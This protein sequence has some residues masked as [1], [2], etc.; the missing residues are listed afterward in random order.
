MRMEQLKKY[1]YCDG[2]GGFRISFLP[3]KGGLDEQNA[4]WVEDIERLIEAL[5]KAMNCKK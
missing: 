5:N 2:F 4:I 1:I 3:E